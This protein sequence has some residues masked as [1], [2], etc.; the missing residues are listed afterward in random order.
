MGNSQTKEVRGHGSS[1]S[2]LGGT[3]SPTTPQDGQT[4]GSEASSRPGHSS[5]Q[6]RGSRGPDFSFLG[7]GTNSDQ[8]PALSEQRRET[9]VERD[10]RKAEKEKAARLKERERSMKEEHVDG[11]YLVTQGVYVGTED[12]NKATVRQLMVSTGV[13]VVDQLLTPTRLRGVWLRSGE[14]STTILNRGQNTSSWPPP[15]ACRSRLQTKFPPSLSI[16][17]QRGSTR[18]GVGNQRSKASRCPSEDAR[19]HSSQTVQDQFHPH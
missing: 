9:K 19:S 13:R 18:T 5:R 8:D 14:A 10:A 16:N 6:R 7:I 15:E 12:F 2:R 3:T 11:G 4:N 17:L 1:T